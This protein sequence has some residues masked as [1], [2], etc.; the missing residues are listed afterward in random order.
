MSSGMHFWPK[1][2]NSIIGPLSHIARL[3]S[4]PTNTK[5]GKDWCACRFVLVHWPTG[6]T[7]GLTTELTTELTTGL[8]TE[9]TTG[10]T[11]GLTPWSFVVRK[12]QS[13]ML[14]LN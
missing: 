2:T 10:L 4:T 3:R 9:L 11:T 14:C 6:L 13:T 8:T 12:S 1:L 5:Q 7:T